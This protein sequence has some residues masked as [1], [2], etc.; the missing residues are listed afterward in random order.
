MYPNPFNISVKDI[1]VDTLLVYITIRMDTTEFNA[2][3][4]ATPP[5]NLHKIGSYYV[6]IQLKN[7]PEGCW[8]YINASDSLK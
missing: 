6:L 3:A 1:I 7:T 4:S 2:A 5:K 8:I